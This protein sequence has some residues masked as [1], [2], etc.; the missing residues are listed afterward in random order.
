MDKA[1]NINDT[2]YIRLGIMFG[3]L[4]PVKRPELK[5]A[6]ASRQTQRKLVRD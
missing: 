3:H 5:D 2:H 6:H 1:N 4:Q